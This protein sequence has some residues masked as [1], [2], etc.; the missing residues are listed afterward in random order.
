MRDRLARHFRIAE[1]PG[2]A[3]GLAEALRSALADMNAAEAG[4]VTCALAVKGEPC[5]RLTLHDEGPI[6]ALLAAGHPTAYARLPVAILHR[7]LVEEIL[8]IAGSGTPDD[9][10]QYTRDAEEALS[11]VEAGRAEA[12][13][14]LTPPRVADVRAI[15]LAGGRMPHKSTYFYPKVLSGLVI[16]PLD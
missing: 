5:V 16:R 3:A 13:L 1:V 2:T 8:E 7:L 6:T 11:A 4:S 10:I 15:A 14:F 12:A 9:A